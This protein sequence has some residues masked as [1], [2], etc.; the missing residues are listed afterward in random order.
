M[1]RIAALK[2]P[3]KFNIS[4]RKYIDDMLIIAKPP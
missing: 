4:T 3:V 1:E 2:I